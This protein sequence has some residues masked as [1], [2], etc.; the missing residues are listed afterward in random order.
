MDRDGNY[1]GGGAPGIY[2]LKLIPINQSPK[3]GRFKLG[4]KEAES[5]EIM[6]PCHCSR[7]PSISQSPDHLV[8]PI[9]ATLISG[10]E[11]HQLP[12]LFSYQ[13]SPLRTSKVETL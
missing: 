6:N 13:K 10:N 4:S 5:Q 1:R 12:C 2:Q 8:S 9:V 7:L 11:I 3:D